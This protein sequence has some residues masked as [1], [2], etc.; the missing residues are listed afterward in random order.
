MFRYLITI[1]RHFNQCYS[2]D[3][4]HSPSLEITRLLIPFFRYPIKKSNRTVTQ[5][6]LQDQ[7]VFLK[8]FYHDRLNNFL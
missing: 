3:E 1:C 4:A 5:N 6:N 2:V 8:K 7:D